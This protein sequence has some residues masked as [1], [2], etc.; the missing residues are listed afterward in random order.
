MD[1]VNGAGLVCALGELGG[2][3]GRGEVG[4]RGGEVGAG[5]GGVLGGGPSLGNA[6]WASGAQVTL[7]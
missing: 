7:R 4:A 5:E 6:L 3:D 2:S 1:G